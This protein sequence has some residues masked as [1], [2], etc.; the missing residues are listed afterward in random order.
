MKKYRFDCHGHNA[1]AYGCNV[2][3][4]NSGEYVLYA[5]VEKTANLV[6]ELRL[7][8]Q[9]MDADERV[10]MLDKLF[11]GYCVHCGSEFLPCYCLND[12]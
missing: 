7:N 4:D 12:E 9:S 1:P 10:E 8:M 5:E 11:D 6:H 2:P 3:G